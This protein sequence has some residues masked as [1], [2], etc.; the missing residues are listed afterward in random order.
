MCEVLNA[1][2]TPHETNGRAS[3]EDD[4]NDFWFGFEQEYFL[5]NP[6]TN[7]PLGFPAN[8]YPAPQ[9]PYYCSVG[10]K[11]AFGRDIV[12][13]HLDVGLDAGLNVRCV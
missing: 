2:A 5:W 7:M 12:E 11:K 4:D 10:A 9:G 3:I 8:G 6:E 13:E 1:D